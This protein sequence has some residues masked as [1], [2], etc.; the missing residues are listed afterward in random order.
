[1]FELQAIN[2]DTSNTVYS[3]AGGAL[4][5]KDKSTLLICPS[6]KTGSFEIPNSVITIGDYAFYECTGLTSITFQEISRVESIGSYAF[7][8]CTGLTS[9]TIPNS[10]KSIGE[11]AF[12]GC[13]SLQNMTI[14]N[15]VTSIGDWAFARSG[16]TSITIPNSITSIANNT[17]KKCIDLTSVIFQENSSVKSIGQS[18]FADS[19]LTSIT[20]PNSVDNISSHAFY[21]CTGLTSITI[22]NSVEN[23]GT[24]TFYKCKSLESVIIPESV[25]NVEDNAF[26]ECSNLSTVYFYG[27]APTM[28]SWVFTGAKFGFKVY[29]LSGKTGF[30]TPKWN[31]YSSA[32]FLD[33]D[34]ATLGLVGTTVTSSAEEVSKGEFSTDQSKIHI[35]PIDTGTATITVKNA[36]SHEATIGVKVTDAKAITIEAITKYGEA[37]SDA[38][39]IAVVSGKEQ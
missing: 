8:E 15:S 39:T 16:L 26:Y 28:G 18:A 35:M 25:T 11:S 31:G 37:D 10:V 20:I 5:N 32:L 14:P 17:F 38:T 21:E 29:Y 4:Y 6:G 2:V 9:I 1:M 12:S 7:C 19:G 30:T 33:N 22:S 3:S 27:D 13:T 23:I 34:E 24:H 36:E